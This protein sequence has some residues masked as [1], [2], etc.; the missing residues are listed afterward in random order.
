[1]RVVRLSIIGGENVVCGE[2]HIALMRSRLRLFCLTRSPV[3][4]ALSCLAGTRTEWRA[5]GK[6]LSPPHP[7]VAHRAAFG[8]DGDEPDQQR[9]PDLDGRTA[10]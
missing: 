4:G 8:F 9:G 6:G 7:L 2:R 3:S 5:P 1:M 10:I